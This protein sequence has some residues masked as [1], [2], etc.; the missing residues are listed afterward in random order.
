MRNWSWFFSYGGE[1]YVI[2]R[3]VLL[4]NQGCLSTHHLTPKHS[5]C[6]FCCC[7]GP[8]V[9]TL[10]SSGVVTLKR[11]QVTDDWIRDHD[12]EGQHP[13]S[14]DHPIG[15]GPGLPHPWLQGVTDGAVALN[16]YSNQA[17]CR[18]AHWYA[19]RKTQQIILNGIKHAHYCLFSYIFPFDEWKSYYVLRIVQTRNKKATKTCLF[20]CTLYLQ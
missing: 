2:L 9:A 19:W 15:M 7:D 3:T 12:N 10:V 11:L 17:K 16:R 8:L 6:L 14:S 20:M 4:K 13:R 1:N 5:P 18:N